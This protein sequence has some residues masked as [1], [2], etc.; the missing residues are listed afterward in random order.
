MITSN[1]DF[2]GL[3]TN[4]KPETYYGLSTD[5]KPITA[6]N[7]SCFIE[8]D[9]STMYFF[10]EEAKEWSIWSSSGGGGGGGG[11]DYQSVVI[12][13]IKNLEL[14]ASEFGYVMQPYLIDYID[15]NFGDL[16]HI[17]IN[18][19]AELDCNTMIF[20]ASDNNFFI[21]GGVSEIEYETGDYDI[22]YCG[23]EGGFIEEGSE[24]YAFA[25]VVFELNPELHDPLPETLTLNLKL[26]KIV[27]VE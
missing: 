9:T 14:N 2:E 18:G 13:D 24:Q 4:N 22:G 5:E 25:L 16:F 15:V 21:E 19:D 8:M 12:L 10:D 6:V 27:P 11:G 20:D 23:I 26:S 17:E 7:G 3:N 1:K